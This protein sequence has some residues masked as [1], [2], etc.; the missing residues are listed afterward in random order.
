MTAL[1]QA[2]ETISIHSPELLYLPVEYSVNVGEC[3]KAGSEEDV[4]G[5]RRG[6]AWDIEDGGGAAGEGTSDGNAR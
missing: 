2:V 4:A 6:Q 1:P 3:E 5:L